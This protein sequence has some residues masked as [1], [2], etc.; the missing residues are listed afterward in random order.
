MVKGE[1]V[2]ERATEKCSMLEHQVSYEASVNPPIHCSVLRSNRWHPAT[3]SSPVLINSPAP[4]RQVC[5]NWGISPNYQAM[6]VCLSSP[7]LVPWSF[8]VYPPASKVEVFWQWR[9]KVA[10]D[11]SNL[12]FAHVLCF[13]G[14]KW[15]HEA[16]TQNGSLVKFGVM[17]YFSNQ[18]NWLSGKIY[19]HFTCNSTHRNIWSYTYI[20]KS[21]NNEM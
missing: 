11:K 2:G 8:D 7:R 12:M 16:K 4:L 10:W 15:F 3:E 6:G 19:C 5:S 14:L 9:A 13:A 1:I 21:T 18:N 17:C 20:L